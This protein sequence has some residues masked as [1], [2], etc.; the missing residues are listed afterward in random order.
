MAGVLLWRGFWCRA[1]HANETKASAMDDDGEESEE[2]QS[3]V[4]EHLAVEVKWRNVNGICLLFLNC[5]MKIT[6][7]NCCKFRSTNRSRLE[8]SRKK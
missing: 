5:G 8:S 1:S 2:Q 6:S 7:S 3:Q 4:S